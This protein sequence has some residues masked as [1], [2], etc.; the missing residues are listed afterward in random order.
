MFRLAA[1]HKVTEYGSCAMALY[2]F[3]AFEETEIT[4]DS[5]DFITHIDQT[6]PRWWQGLGPDGNY[7]LFPANQVKLVDPSTI[8]A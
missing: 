3:Q 8:Q 7:G 1:I 2:D 4:F 6:D 5:G